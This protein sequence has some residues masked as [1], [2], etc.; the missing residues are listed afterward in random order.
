MTTATLNGVT[1]ARSDSTEMVE[2]N[3]YFPSDSVNWDLFAK[4]DRSTHCPWK[5][6]ASYYDVTADGQ[7]AENVAWQYEAPL[8]KATHIKD[9]V[10]FYP[11]VSV[12]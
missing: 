5:G 4:T 8:E 1:L 12:A 11:A 9:Y 10:A 7:T 6:D 2:G 3:H